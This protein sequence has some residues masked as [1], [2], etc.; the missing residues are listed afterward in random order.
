[1]ARRAPEMPRSAAARAPGGTGT[2]PQFPVT[3]NEHAQTVLHTN[4]RRICLWRF[5]PAKPNVNRAARNQRDGK[6]K[7]SGPT[8]DRHSE[9]RYMTCGRLP[10][11]GMKRRSTK[12]GS[13][14]SCQIKQTAEIGRKG[15][16]DTLTTPP[17]GP[18]KRESCTHFPAARADR[19]PPRQN[20]LPAK[21][22][23]S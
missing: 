14:A 22:R 23:R 6:D 4:H 19:A 17:D 13:F 20:C 2:L 21:A 10:S 18:A 9:R 7:D 3:L 1:M 5:L 16:P 8:E 15:N 11:F 12:M